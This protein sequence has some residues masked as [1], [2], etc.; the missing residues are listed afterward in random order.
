MR[1]RQERAHHTASSR[2]RIAPWPERQR[3]GRDEA[4]EG[5]KEAEANQRR[6]RREAEVR[7]MSGRGEADVR[8]R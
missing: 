7:R 4:K 2:L 5:K 8:Q 3:R 1:K 6:G